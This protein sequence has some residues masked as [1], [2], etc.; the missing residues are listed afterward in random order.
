MGLPTAADASR[1]D[2]THP[3]CMAMRTFEPRQ[4][5]Q[6][7]GGAGPRCAEAPGWEAGTPVMWAVDAPSPSPPPPTRLP[8]ASRRPRVS[9]VVLTL[10]QC[11]A[12]PW[13]GCCWSRRHGRAGAGAK[14]WPDPVPCARHEI[15]TR[16]LH[17]ALAWQRLPEQRIGDA[18]H[19]VL[20]EI[21]TGLQV[22]GSAT[23]ATTRCRAFTLHGAS[24]FADLHGTCRADGS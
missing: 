5:C 17:A 19:D 10:S 12:I 14:P 20:V 24:M 15:T 11:C 8:P 1:A 6:K 9:C 23:V 13:T 21:V 2:E 3:K 18:T 4:P 22:H 7:R 16:H